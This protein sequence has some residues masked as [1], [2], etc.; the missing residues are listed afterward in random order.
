MLKNEFQ[1]CKNLVN[2][3]VDDYLHGD[4]DALI[5][6][7]FAFLEDDKIY[8]CNAR[9]FD[10]DDTNLTRALC[11]LLWGDAFPCLSLS[12]IGTGKKYRGDTINT[13]NTVL[14]TYLPEKQTSKGVLKSEAPP[15]IRS[16]TNQFHSVYHTIG[17]FILLPNVAETD[18]K[19]AYTLNTYR[20]VAY[21]DYFD[22]FLQ[23]LSYVAK[24]YKISV[25]I[26]PFTILLQPVRRISRG[27]GASPLRRR[28]LLWY[29]V[30]NK[31]LCGGHERR[32]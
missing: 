27:G 4:F 9:S 22:L 3:F 31:I 13:F 18:T 16:I 25:I 8:G 1:V 30:P 29:N 28:V 23:Q 14:G 32:P 12:D 24:R 7:D 19:R 6:F 15:E 17:N 26:R 2:D 11:F 20:G 10:C 5:N 21:K